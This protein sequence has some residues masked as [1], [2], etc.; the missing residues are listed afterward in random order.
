MQNVEETQ[1]SDEV[2]TV[3]VDEASL[4]HSSSPEIEKAQVLQQNFMELSA[5]EEE[6]SEVR[7]CVRFSMG[8]GPQGYTHPKLKVIFGINEVTSSSVLLSISV[9]GTLHQLHHLNDRVRIHSIK[10]T[11]WLSFYERIIRDLFQ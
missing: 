2:K 8:P 6:I 5:S 9:L 7:Q 1:S 11:K 4:T 10:H 3:E